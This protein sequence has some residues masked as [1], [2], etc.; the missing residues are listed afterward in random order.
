[1]SKTWIF[2][3]VLLSPIWS[4]PAWAACTNLPQKTPT[5]RWALAECFFK[6]GSILR[7]AEALDQMVD[8]HPREI[9]AAATGAWLYWQEST[10]VGGSEEKKRIEQA[11][12][13]L[14]RARSANP[15][16]WELYTEIGDFY[17]LRLNQADQAYAFYLKARELAS[18]DSS[19]KI[20]EASPGRKAAIENRI[21]RSAEQLDRKGEAVEASCRALFFDPDDATA[22]RRVEKLFGSCVRKQVKNPSQA[23]SKNEDKAPEATN[24]Q[25]AKT[26][27][28]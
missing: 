5:E 6:S 26:S 8:A 13:L 21:A 14:S 11:L 4:R 20:P 15:S 10:R 12:G 19:R 17:S 23:N 27:K 2:V 18:G 24:P 28:P 3:I 22:K 16:S 7:A 25:P 9:E 1:M